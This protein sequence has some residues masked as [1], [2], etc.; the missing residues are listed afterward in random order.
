MLPPPVDPTGARFPAE[1]VPRLALGGAWRTRAFAHALAH[2]LRRVPGGEPQAA[3]AAR[4]AAALRASDAFLAHPSLA[5][6]DDP[7]TLVQ[8]RLRAEPLPNCESLAEVAM[9][10]V[11]FGSALDQQLRALAG[12]SD[13][14]IAAAARAVTPAPAFGAP[15]IAA[16]AHDPPNRRCLQILV[17]RWLGAACLVFGRPGTV[18]DAEL[19]QRGVRPAAREALASYLG[20]IEEQLWGWGLQAT[21][22]P[23][24]GIIAPDGWAP[25]RRPATTARRDRS[26]SGAAAHHE[27]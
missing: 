13:S 20:R 24:M 7:E 18:A 15:I 19:G 26:S 12:S 5:T 25:R 21:D 2:G 11:L 14:A 8:A 3:V 17:D 4:I 16:L 23:F 6:G 27:E 10:D 1:P 22:A 9:A